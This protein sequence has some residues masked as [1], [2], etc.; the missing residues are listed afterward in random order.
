MSDPQGRPT[1]QAPQFRRAVAAFGPRP[2]PTPPAARARLNYF[3]AGFILAVGL[4]G[5]V[6]AVNPKTYR[7]LDSVDLV[8]HEAGHLIFGLFGEFIGILGGSLMQVLIPAIVT[9]YFILYNQRWSGMVT[10]F[11]VGQ[12]LF[13]VSVYVRD[14]RAQALPLLGG[15]DVLHD[16]N[17]LLAK[18]H[19]LRWDQ[20]IGAVIYM[21]GL[22]AVVASVVGGLYF[23]LE[24]QA[25]ED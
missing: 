6:C 5:V 24:D 25:A 7:F 16:W 17:W 23:S 10:L 18:L 8:F 19:L 3:K 12:S 11:W 21:A 1:P 2:R 13:N 22:L 9:G 14:A 4:Y 20:A 15:E